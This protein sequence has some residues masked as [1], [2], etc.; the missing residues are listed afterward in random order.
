MSSSSDSST[1]IPEIPFRPRLVCYQQTYHDPD[2]RY[3]PLEPL[4]HRSSVTHIILAALHLNHDCVTLNDHPPTDP[5]YDRLWAEVR[6]LRRARGIKVLVMLGGAA[7]GT[8]ER[9]DSRDE[10]TYEGYYSMLRDALRGMPVDGVDLDVEEPMAVE[11]AVRLIEAVKRDFGS[12]FIVTLAPVA[13]GLVSMA[14]LSGFDYRELERRAGEHIAWY[15]TQFYCGWG[16]FDDPMCYDQIIQQGWRPQKVVAGLLTNPENGAQGYVSMDI[17]A[18]VLSVLCE[19][20]P[21][22]GGVMGWE[23]FNGLPGGPEKPWQWA[24]CISLIFGMKTIHENVKKLLGIGSVPRRLN[25]RRS[26]SS[27]LRRSN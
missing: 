4:S 3:T 12:E 1:T 24:E 16:Y 8:F 23:Y 9:L 17:L 14:H 15:N 27:L 19:K 6:E 11:H 25:R 2:G 21:G 18:Y 22:F 26:S 20:Y 13:T 5:I 7:R 10:A